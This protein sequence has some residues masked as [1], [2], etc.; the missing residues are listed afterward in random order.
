MKLY[1]EGVEVNDEEE[2]DDDEDEEEDEEVL[3]VDGEVIEYEQ[4]NQFN[5]K[6]NGDG[7]NEDEDDIGIEIGFCIDDRIDDQYQDGEMNGDVDIG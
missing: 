3:I 4:G 2:D 7:Y 1:V 5:Y 6:L